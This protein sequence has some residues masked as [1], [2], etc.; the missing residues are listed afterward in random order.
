ML[1]PSASKSAPRI[2]LMKAH[3]VD[4]RIFGNANVDGYGSLAIKGHLIL[5]N[6]DRKNK[7]AIAELELNNHSYIISITG[8]GKGPKLSG[9][10]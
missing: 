3:L 7:S 8:K 4:S 1:I 6:R 5:K 10:L 2:V 9:K